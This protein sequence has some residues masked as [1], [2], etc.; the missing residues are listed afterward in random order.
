MLMDL[1][2][3]S[4]LC[5]DV[6]TGKVLTKIS[7]SV[8]QHREKCWMNCSEIVSASVNCEEFGSAERT[9]FHKGFKKSKWICGPNRYW[10]QNENGN[11]HKTADLS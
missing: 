8:L 1:N 4:N 3:I 11:N 9:R 5:L 10:Y 2:S 7:A 6:T